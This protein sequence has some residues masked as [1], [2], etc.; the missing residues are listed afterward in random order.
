MPELYGIEGQCLSYEFATPWGNSSVRGNEL[1][2]EH[3]DLYS[4]NSEGFRCDEF[5]PK[6]H[7][8]SLLFSGCSN[9]FGQG[10]KN[11]QDTWSHKLYTAI[12]KDE[13]TS[14]Y[15][16]IG[17]PGANF[18]LIVS[19]IMKY[20]NRFG[21][22]DIIFILFPPI[23]RFYAFKDDSYRL[24]VYGAEDEE[25]VRVIKAINFQMYL[26]LDQ[27]CRSNNIKLFSSAWDL[28]KDYS[29]FNCSETFDIGDINSVTKKLM[30]IVLKHSERKD[31]LEVE[32][33]HYGFAYQELWFERFYDRYLR[34]LD[35]NIR[36]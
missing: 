8:L 9:T 1:P 20:C 5:V 26:C 28:S 2:E 17:T 22:P 33:G 6:D 25:M 24:G 19:N 31:L 4:L 23:E 18:P 30:E 3:K 15:F 11:I 32:D 12:S 29:I 7:K 13:E 36:D 35:V 14:G 10:T 16:N 27:Y 21:N 34:D